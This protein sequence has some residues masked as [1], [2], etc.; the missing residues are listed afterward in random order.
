MIILDL[1]SQADA[2]ETTIQ[3]YGLEKYIS[4]FWDDPL[5]TQW[6]NEKVEGPDQAPL[7]AWQKS[8]PLL[9]FNK[10]G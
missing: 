1:Y 8:K 7:V 10:M 2:A 4:R 3:A 9:Q 6:G 5:T